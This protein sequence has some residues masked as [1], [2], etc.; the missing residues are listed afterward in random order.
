MGFSVT[1]AH[2]IFGIAL[3]TASAAAASAYWQNQTHIEES[4]RAMMERAI[5]LAQ[6]NLTITDWQW[7]PGAPG[8]LEFTLTNKG[9]N[10]LDHTRFDYLL[11]GVPTFA[12]MEAGYPLL[13]GAPTTSSLVLPGDALG[14]MY[15][16]GSEPTT[17][18]VA[19]ENGFVAHYPG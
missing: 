4:R 13:N 8:T 19:A 1:A 9:T 12:S 2:V 10:V 17:L 7:T 18:Q 5:D 15:A 16:L 6:T 11:D 14:C 3:L